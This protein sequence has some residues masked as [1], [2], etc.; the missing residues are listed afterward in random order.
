MRAAPWAGMALLAVLWLQARSDSPPERLVPPETLPALYEAAEPARGRLAASPAQIPPDGWKDVLWRTWHEFGRDRVMAIS[1]GVTFYT[2][3]AIFPATAA[4]VS[5]YGLFFDVDQVSAQLS[6]LAAFV[7][8]SALSL[9]E[10]QMVRLATARTDALSLAFVVSLFLSVWA[11]NASMN[12]LFLGLNVVYGEREKRNF[13]YRRVVTYGF[14]FAGL[15]FATAATAI[16]V[17]V[18]IVLRLL[19]LGETLLVPLRWLLLLLLTACVFAVV[20]RYGPS[21]RPARWSWVMLGAGAAA[22]AWIVTSLGFSWWVNHLANFDATYG[23]LG[24][25]MVFMMW[26]WVS[27]VVVLLG[28]ELNAE[29]EHQTARDSTTGP[30]RPIGSRGARMADGVGPS[31][32]GVR[33][34][35]RLAWAILERQAGWLRRN[36][37][38]VLPW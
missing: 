37:Q 18:P 32:G 33:N 13:F 31:S 24:T 38:T 30:E 34:Q 12:A 3:L 11:A 17:A 5:L 27:I 36:S 15:V 29:M 9:I 28:G 23:P 10:G 16:L 4:F 22:V 26:I 8:A 7:P 20:Y 14:T 25:V 35:A 1:A 6:D 21:R 19:E 2:L